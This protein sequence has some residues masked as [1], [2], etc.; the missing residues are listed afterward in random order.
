MIDIMRV[1]N[2]P[3]L[4]AQNVTVPERVTAV[5]VPIQGGNCNDMVYAASRLLRHMFC[6]T[7]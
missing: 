6:G 5:F 7:K 1:V 3:F 4:Y 2:K